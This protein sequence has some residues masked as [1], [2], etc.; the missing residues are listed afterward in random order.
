MNTRDVRILTA[1]TVARIVLVPAIMALVLIGDERRYAYVAAAVLFVIA[2]LTD[3]VDGYLARRWSLTTTLGSFLDTTAD[4]LLVSGALIALV[5]VERVS[6]WVVVIIVSRELA[7][8]ALRGMVAAEGRLMKPSIWG[9]LK[10]NVQFVAV[11]MAMARA[12]WELGGL[13]PDEWAMLIA[14]GITILSAVEYFNRFGAALTPAS[15]E[16]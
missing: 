3:F 13:Y 14:A 8:L 12:S 2:A 1:I 15:P 10:A 9:K 11:A 4:K 16:E 5:A 6:P 7:V